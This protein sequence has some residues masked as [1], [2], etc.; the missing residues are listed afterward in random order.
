MRTNNI[1]NSIEDF[2]TFLESN[3]AVLVYFSTTSCSVGE[4]LEPKV[5]SLLADSFPKIKL[6]SADLNNNAKIATHFNAFVEPTILIF[7]EG[8]E[9]IRRSRNIS[10]FELEEA[11]KRPY[12][13][14]F[15]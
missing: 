12:Q 9:T 10:I 11:I 8:K 14:I 6:I 3:S 5:E 15:E 7:F 13:L 2:Y 1:Y 4:A